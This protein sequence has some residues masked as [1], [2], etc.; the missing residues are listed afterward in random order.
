MS[1]RGIAHMGIGR[2]SGEHRVEEAIKMAID[3]PLLETSIKRNPEYWLW[4]HN[5]WKRTREQFNAEYPEEERQ[6]ILS[7]L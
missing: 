4:S 2:A 1:D 5:R 6:R 3:S 7:K